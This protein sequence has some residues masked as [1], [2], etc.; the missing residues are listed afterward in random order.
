MALARGSL[1]RRASEVPINPID[2]RRPNRVSREAVVALES[3]HE[4]FSRRLSTVWNTRAHTLVE[5][6]HVA[7]EQLSIDDFAL[8]L[9]IPTALASVRAERIGATMYVQVDLPVALLLVERLLGGRGDPTANP[10]GRRPTDLETALLSRELIEPA[11]DAIDECLAGLEGPPSVMVNFDTTPQPLRLVSASELLLLFT[12][13]VTL[14]GVAASQGLLTLAYPVG[15]LLANI[16][17]IVSTVTHDDAL[18]DPGEASPVRQQLLE[19]PLDVSVRL[20]DSAFAVH[21]VAHVGVGDVIRLDHHVARPMRLMLDD[22]CV[23][24]VHLGRRGRRMAVQVSQMRSR[25]TDDVANPASPAPSSP[26]DGFPPPRRP[27]AADT[28]P[29]DATDPS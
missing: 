17:E 27:V 23:A 14:H 7:T 9:A 20:D 29:A 6:E 4:T 3:Q 16:D 25:L 2:F 22:R 28:T 8:S 26:Q 5:I 12:F 19:A 21:D 24:D 10:V 15:P 11:V 18:L 1:H 13:R